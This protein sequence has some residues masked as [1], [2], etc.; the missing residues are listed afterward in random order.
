MTLDR[1]WNNVVLL[2]PLSAEPFT[3]D[4]HGYTVNQGTT[5][6]EMTDPEVTYIFDNVPVAVFLGET[7]A[8]SGNNGTQLRIGST[9]D[10]T[11]GSG[12]FTIEAWCSYA[13]GAPPDDTS[14]GV[15]APDEYTPYPI[16]ERS[17]GTATGAWS[18]EFYSNRN[19]LDAPAEDEITQYITFYCGDYA[20]SSAMMSFQQDVDDPFSQWHH[21]A[22]TRNGNEW[23]LWM[24]GVPV[25]RQIATTTIATP[26]G[27]GADI[28]IGNSILDT[29]SSG[30]SQTDGRGFPGWIGQVRITKGYARYTRSFEPAFIDLNAPPGAA[31][32]SG[33][34]EGDYSGSTYRGA[35]G[36]Q[37]NPATGEPEPGEP[38][39]GKVSLSVV[40]PD[41]PAQ[42]DVRDQN[43][44]RRV[45]MDAM[46]QAAN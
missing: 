5:D 24:Q 21:Y 19:H 10:F 44:T 2:V 34:D 27:A 15:E 45:I 32:P 41:P 4:R 22:V 11:L 35:T 8:A 3:E 9:D 6:V 40:L 39:Q 1:F 42:Y 30:F 12:D 29:S 33:N 14:I 17:N 46:R 20:A 7:S 31:L 37:G 16:I 23:T 36:A 26:S 38:G 28:R 25:D 18:L 43:E 13:G